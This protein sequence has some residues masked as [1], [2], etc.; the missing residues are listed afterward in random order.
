MPVVPV[1]VAELLMT[2]GLP[3]LT[4]SVRVPVP[5][6]AMFVALI[7]IVNDPVE[8]GVPEITPVW[9]LTVNPL[10]NPVAAKLVGRLVAV[11]A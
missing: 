3:K 2:G 6:P 7:G 4:V 5:V 1:A 10:G 9:V 11:I 8:A